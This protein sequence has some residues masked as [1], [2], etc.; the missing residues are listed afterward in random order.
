MESVRATEM[1]TAEGSV[2]HITM[3]LGV[4]TERKGMEFA[5]V[6]K[7]ADDKLYKGK[8]N[9]KNQVV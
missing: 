2:F 4:A 5:E 3:T 6:V 7:E 8:H 9:G 1:H